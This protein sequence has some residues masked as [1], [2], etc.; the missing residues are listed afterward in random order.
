MMYGPRG[1]C[2]EADTNNFRL[3][4]KCQVSSLQSQPA[5]DSPTE[6]ELQML[7]IVMYLNPMQLL[8]E[9]CKISN[10]INQTSYNQGMLYGNSCYM[11]IVVIW[12]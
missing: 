6:Q 2:L 12:Q 7:S 8:L 11:A 5:L 3:H 1:R 4:V 9:M 10:I